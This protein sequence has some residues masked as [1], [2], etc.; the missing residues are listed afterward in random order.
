MNPTISILFP[1]YNAADT[2]RRAIAS[3]QI[4][5]FS[6]WELIVVNDGSSDSTGE[7]VQRL[8]A[9]DHR[10]HLHEQ[11]HKGIVAALQLAVSNAKGPFFARMDADDVA[12]PDR[13]MKQLAL[14][15]A[16]PELGLCGT[17]V[18]MSGPVVEDGRRQYGAWINSL[19]TH[20]DIIRELF[21]ECPLPHPTFL[22]RREAYHC[23]GGY[24]DG[25][26]AEDYDLVFRMWRQG[27]HFA[28]MP[29]ILLD[30]Y[31]SPRRLSMCD[32]RYSEQSFRALKRF[33]LF[34]TYLK[35]KKPFFQWGAGEVGKRWLREWTE[36][37]PIAVADIR[38][39]KVGQTIHSY[40]VIK[41]E[42]LPAPGSA[43]I[44]IA[45]GT[46]GARSIIRKWLY[47]RK[48]KECRDFVF[49]A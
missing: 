24:M 25:P 39:G 14:L 36:H 26:W 5:H 11:P 27:V 47:E 40:P 4:Q 22:M 33:H 44:V 45:V 2:V 28:K 6:D 13:L 9:V 8:A 30:W 48:Y 32:P 29:E 35:D 18:Q 23:A 46:P 12:H 41:P 7:E 1:A 19:N 20:E 31:E 21:V 37:R 10:I 38:P 34:A 15:E 17:G 43:F 42:E 49:L 3:L 16:N